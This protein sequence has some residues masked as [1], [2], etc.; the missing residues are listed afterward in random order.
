MS[1]VARL[2][3]RSVRLRHPAQLVVAGS[4]S[5]W[6]SAPRYLFGFSDD[7]S[8]THFLLIIG[9]AQLDIAIL[10]RWDPTNDF[11]VGH[12][13]PAEGAAALTECSINRLDT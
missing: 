10:T 8:A 4:L 3:L 12:R 11:A 9:I 5:P 13:A 7:G 1:A 2:S 6:P